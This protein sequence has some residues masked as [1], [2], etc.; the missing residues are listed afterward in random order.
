[1]IIKER[2]GVG[3]GA[4]T[5]NMSGLFCIVGLWIWWDGRR[6][7]LC[8]LEISLATIFIRC[9]DYFG[10]PRVALKDTDVACYTTLP[11]T[12]C[13]G[14]KPRTSIRKSLGFGMV[15]AI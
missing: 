6:V 10:Y 12:S 5:V 15:D 9:K 3:D 2:R 11:N 13:R 1:M 4:D 7:A 8:S 14:F